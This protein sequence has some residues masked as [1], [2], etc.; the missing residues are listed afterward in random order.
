[1]VLAIEKKNLLKWK[2]RVGRA[3]KTG[4]SFFVDQTT[5]LGSFKAFFGCFGLPSFPTKVP[6]STY[7]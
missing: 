1:M 3:C 5:N 4:F 6:P 2:T 7:T